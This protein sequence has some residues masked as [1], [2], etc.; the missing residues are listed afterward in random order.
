M[1]AEAHVVQHL[2]MV[3]ACLGEPEEGGVCA[4]A[5][6]PARAGHQEGAAGHGRV[7]ARRLFY[8][9]LLRPCLG[10]LREYRVSTGSWQDV[11]AQP[12]AEKESVEERC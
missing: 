10:L 3:V 9:R 8:A 12:V 11:M 5:G 4:G 2:V 7:C 6:V 1:L